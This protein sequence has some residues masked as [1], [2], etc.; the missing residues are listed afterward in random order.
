[1][2]GLLKR[3]QQGTEISVVY[4][5]TLTSWQMA[6]FCPKDACSILASILN[7]IL[8]KCVGLQARHR[9]FSCQTFKHIS[10]ANVL[11]KLPSK[12][13]CWSCWTISAIV[14]NSF[15]PEHV[16]CS[17]FLTPASSLLFSSGHP[18]RR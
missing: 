12:Q 8:F 3:L 11:C 9:S 10:M 14:M 6:N 18:G 2:K 15:P 17:H 5:K 7:D 1:L 4:C 13:N 16:P